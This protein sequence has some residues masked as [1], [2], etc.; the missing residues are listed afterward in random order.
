MVQGVAD[1]AKNISV[2]PGYDANC[3]M[4]PVVSAEQLDRVTGYISAGKAENAEILAGGERISRPGYFV[5][6]TVLA[7]TQKMSVVQEE[8]FGPVV[9]AMPFGDDEEVL[10][11]AND[12]RYG[13]AASIWTQNLS[14]AHRLASSIE[15]GTVWVN[16]HNVFDPN[17]PFGGAKESGIGRELGKAS[18]DGYLEDKTVLMKLS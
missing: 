15:A 18:I 3:Q 1:F 4:G 5:S 7:T 11:L 12:T 17:L 2:T 10:R 14:S 13:L 8:I 9:C 6:P 16:C